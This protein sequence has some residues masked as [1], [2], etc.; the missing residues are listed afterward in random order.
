MLPLAFFIAIFFNT[1]KVTE[2]VNI[3]LSTLLSKT[4]ANDCYQ[5]QFQRF[6]KYRIL[7]PIFHNL[8]L[9]ALV[10]VVKV[11]QIELFIEPQ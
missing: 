3:V 6:C 1:F 4:N 7:F 10:C 5:F 11:K 2:I 9:S 8:N